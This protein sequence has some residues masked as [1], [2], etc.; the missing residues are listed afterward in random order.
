MKTKTY[1]IFRPSSLPARTIR[2]EDG[3][4]DSTRQASFM[5]KA[6]DFAPG[7]TVRERMTGKGGL[8]ARSR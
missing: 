5:A 7:W 1:L 2:W 3:A 6:D 4:T 8:R